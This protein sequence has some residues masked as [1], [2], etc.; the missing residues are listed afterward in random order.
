MQQVSIYPL[1][2]SS[3]QYTNACI[4]VYKLHSWSSPSSLLVYLRLVPSAIQ[5]S[6]LHQKNVHLQDG[7]HILVDLMGHTTGARLDIVVTTVQGLIVVLSLLLL[8]FL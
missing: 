8:Y 4:N 6:I 7:I 2:V 5:L 3:R 1:G